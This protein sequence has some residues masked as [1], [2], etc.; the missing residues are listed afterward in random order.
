MNS[1]KFFAWQNAA[2]LACLFFSGATP[3]SA[4]HLLKHDDAQPKPMVMHTAAKTKVVAHSTAFETHN[5]NPFSKRNRYLK[6]LEKATKAGGG[7]NNMYVPFQN[8]MWSP[9]FKTTKLNPGHWWHHSR[10][11]A[12]ARAVA[13]RPKKHWKFF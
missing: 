3:A 5:H 12:P 4:F 13:A 8:S 7:N 1:K 11:G 6:R 9:Q 10:N 2:A